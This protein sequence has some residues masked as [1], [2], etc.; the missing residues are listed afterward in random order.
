MIKILKSNRKENKLSTRR[1]YY[2]ML[3]GWWIYIIVWIGAAL[4]IYYIL[5]APIYA[6]VLLYL[7]VIFGTPD[8]QDQFKSYESYKREFEQAKQEEE[9]E[10]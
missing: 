3:V 1:S 8:L 10:Q 5:D 6:K 4:A 2:L 7:V 9:S